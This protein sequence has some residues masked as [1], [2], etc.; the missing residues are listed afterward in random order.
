[1]GL[2]WWLIF[3]TLLLIDLLSYRYDFFLNVA[4]VISLIFFLGTFI[5]YLL[6]HSLS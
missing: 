4:L 2:W 3:G 5:W 1:M 6:E